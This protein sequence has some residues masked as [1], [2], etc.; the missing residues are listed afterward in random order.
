MIPGRGEESGKGM[1]ESMTSPLGA[2]SGRKCPE[3]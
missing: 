1:A 3:K 2:K